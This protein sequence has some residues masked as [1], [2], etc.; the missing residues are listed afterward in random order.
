MRQFFILLNR[1]VAAFFYSMVA[2]VVLFCFLILIGFNFYITVSFMN[3]GP[4]EI[5][6]L[7]AFF[8]TVPTWI[9]LLLVSPIITMR[10]FSEEFKLGTIEPLMTAPV[11]DWQVVLS[12]YLAALLF[13]VILWLPSAAYF[14]IFEAITK[15]HAAWSL[16]AYYGC[17]TFILLFG[18]LYTAIGCLASVLTSNQ[19]IAA[20]L[21]LAANIILF[22]SGLLSF[23]VLNVTPL[24]RDMVGYFS[25]LEHMMNFSRGIFDTRPIA[26][27]LSMTVLVLAITY[28]VFQSRKWK[29]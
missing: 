6:V 21:A 20:I 1:E 17:Y 14:P 7:E 27:Y 28:Q 15:T 2:Y 24:F 18:M 22:L 16:G 25:S 3:R 26:W 4:S 10:L 9:C 23:F 5:T 19:I 12:K 11:Q 13:Y 29:V 8:N